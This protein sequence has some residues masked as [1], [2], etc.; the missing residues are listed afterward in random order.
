MT[1]VKFC[2]LSRSEDIAAVNIL[3]PDYAGFVF[4]EKSRRYVAPE[5]AK[6]LSDKLNPDIVP[7]GVFLDSDLNRI[8]DIANTGCIRTVQ[9]HGSESEGFVR[10]TRDATG[11]PVIRAF[12]IATRNDLEKAISTEA[13]LMMLDGGIGEGRTFDWSLLED[14][15]RP[16]I[17][18]GGLNPDNV[19]EAIER[20]HPFGVDVSSGIETDGIKDQD[21]MKR[22]MEAVDSARHSYGGA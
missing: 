17:L 6:M 12:R 22:F 7:V 15:K 1:C 2:G 5:T 13:D 16:Y 14:V 21:K 20:L 10:E 19:K 3:N 4:W 18:A 9:L 11:M 8:I